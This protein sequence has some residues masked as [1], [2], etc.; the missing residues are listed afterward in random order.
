MAWNMTSY[1]KAVVSA[2]RNKLSTFDRVVKALKMFVENEGR[3]G[4]LSWIALLSGH[5]MKH[6]L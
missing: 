4:V 6:M 2:W 1:F 3:S 5:I